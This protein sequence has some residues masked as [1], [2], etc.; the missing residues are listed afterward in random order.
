MLAVVVVTIAWKIVTVLF[1][2]TYKPQGKI[3]MA[4]DDEAGKKGKPY[5]KEE[6]IQVCLFSAHGH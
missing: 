2:G 3:G 4:D 1:L 5:S 6:D